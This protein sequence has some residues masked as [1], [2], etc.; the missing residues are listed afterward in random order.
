MDFENERENIANM[1][2]SY[3]VE[4]NRRDNAIE[5]KKA[6]GKALVDDKINEFQEQY[7][8][9]ERQIKDAKNRLEK[10]KEQ[11]ENDIDRYVSSYSNNYYNG[12]DSRIR[13][14]LEKEYGKRIA[15]LE[16]YIDYLESRRRES[17][18][19][20]GKDV[21]DLK[22]KN[23]EDIKAIEKH[24]NVYS[25]VDLRMRAY[26]KDI[27]RKNLTLAREKL[28]TELLDRQSKILELKKEIE[29]ISTVE[30]ENQLNKAESIYDEIKLRIENGIPIVGN[31]H[32]L[33]M[34]YELSKRLKEAIDRTNVQRDDKIEQLNSLMNEMNELTDVLNDYDAAIDS[35][36]YTEEESA[37]LLRSLAPWEQEE[38]DRRINK[39]KEVLGEKTNELEEILNEDKIDPEELV[40]PEESTLEPP[41]IPNNLELDSF[42]IGNVHA[43][44]VHSGD[45]NLQ[46]VS[47]IEVDN[48]N[49]ALS[50]MLTD[51]LENVKSLKRIKLTNNDDNISLEVNRELV[52]NVE[53]QKGLKLPNGNYINAASLCSAIENYKNKIAEKAY[54][55]KTYVVKGISKA[56]TLTKENIKELKNMVCM[57]SKISLMPNM[58]N[59]KNV[60][61][62]ES[63]LKAGV[64]KVNQLL[65]QPI[66]IPDEFADEYVSFRD[67][68][69][70][71]NQT[72]AEKKG[73]WRDKLKKSLSKENIKNKVSEIYNKMKIYIPNKEDLKNAFDLYEY[74]D[75]KDTKTK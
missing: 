53:N 5:S 70:I 4:A 56:Y 46:Q 29:E 35:M 30:L 18:T 43:P 6:E 22:Q 68:M 45:E 33:K 13:N 40:F 12:E 71:L 49:S 61:A 57:A 16:N 19:T 62:S 15:E 74:A 31:G 32:E 52:A 26:E 47:D 2:E 67:L 38:L 3:N 63:M 9:F 54:Q 23:I 75:N 72:F 65:G 58:N 28:N 14:D 59:D 39:S 64:P 24:S 69:T 44:E 73:T 27:V 36:K 51:I 42:N 11:K 50:G 41:E 55:P 20:Y 66:S 60:I 10:L 21:Y 48:L 25:N 17:R 34:S 1:M 37:S 8:E 7:D